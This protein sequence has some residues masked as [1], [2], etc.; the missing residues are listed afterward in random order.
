MEETIFFSFEGFDKNLIAQI[1]NFFKSKKSS[2]TKV[3]K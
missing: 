3:K 2:K 1:K